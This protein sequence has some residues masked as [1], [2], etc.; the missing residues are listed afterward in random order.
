MTP[1]EITD[2]YNGIVFS[3]DNKEL[4]NAFDSLRQLI[5]AT[6]E[7]SFLDKLNEL[8]ET[9]KYMLRYRAEGADDPMRQQIYHNLLISAYELA[10][11][12]KHKL[13]TNESALT[14]Y[15]RR[16]TARSIPPATFRELE[17]KLALSAEAGERAGFD[18]AV[19]DLFSRI[20]ISD[21]LPLEDAAL[22]QQLLL[23]ESASYVACEAVSALTLALQETF[24][25]RKLMLLFDAADHASPQVRIRALIGILLTLYSYRQRMYLYP[26]AAERL[27]ELAEQPSFLPLLRTV[28]LKFILS[29]ETEKITRK[30]QNE[31]LP[32][33]MKIT[34][35]LKR[36]LN[37][38]DFN[39]ETASDGMNPE[40]EDILKDNGLADRLKEFSEL[41]MEGA[42]VMHSSFVHLKTYPFF[43]EI[44]NWFL[45][46]TAEHS[47]IAGHRLFNDKDSS[48]LEA[49][50]GSSFLCNSDKYSIYFSMMHIP[51]EQRNMIANQFS[52]ESSEM[53]EQNRELQ[54][55]RQKEEAIIGQYIQDLY[56]FYKVHPQHAEFNDIFDLPLDFHNL[57]TIRP[58][59]AD[60]ESL[61]VLAEYYLKKKYYAD[62]LVLFRELA[63]RT[64]TDAVLFQKIGFC[65]ESEEKYAEALEA[66]TRAE[67]L[68]SGNKW[69]LRHIARLYRFL[70]RPDEA[71]SYYT[72]LESL[73]PDNLSVQ[74][75]IGHCYLELKAYDKALK[76]FFKVDYLDGKSHKAWR[77]IAW[78]SFVTGKL[79]Q[80]YHYYRKILDE[81][82]NEQDFLNAGHT[83]WAFR[84]PQEAL[85]CY[86][87]SVQS[88]NNNFHKFMEQFRQDL[89][90]LK[91]AGI[92]DNDVPLM[93]DELRYRLE[94]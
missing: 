6:R 81:Q 71:L 1:Q 38:E 84:R 86:Q 44:G 63:E 14:F 64:P 21:R 11:T 80:A 9:Y 92:D 69:T 15:S 35:K 76:C 49:L 27:A 72:R 48:L 75:N 54:N 73:E 47:A 55:P 74:I 61:S 52:G 29:R 68:D 88:Q 65:L 19:T 18:R 22:L 34:P 41:Q 94:E 32:E 12:L 36:K 51:A 79:E 78:C 45:P 8:H 24:D 50:T 77:P 89:P 83:A 85:T 87:R 66:Y 67:L 5:A 26:K 3:L 16:R 33:M 28:I 53:M 46:F 56:R 2:Y 30:L 25:E 58:Y 40:W 7:Y 23:D 31:L 82:P 60:S 93:L 4:K 59:I 13:L 42:D 91:A 10:D 62:A 39:A 70:S 20:W 37:M 57:P 17:T 90:E 43:R